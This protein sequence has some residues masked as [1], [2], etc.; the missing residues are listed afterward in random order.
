VFKNIQDYYSLFGARGV[1]LAIKARCRQTC[2]QFGVAVPG[3]KHLVYLRFR[4]SD[5]S[6]F[7]QVVVRRG[8]DIDLSTSPRFIVDAG[9]NVGLT[10]VFY[11]NKY[12]EAKILAIEPEESNFML[13]KKNSAF[14][15]QI[16]PVQRALWNSNEEL[17][18][19]D[20]GL[21]EWAF[22]TRHEPL[23]ACSR[24]RT[25]GLTM[26]QVLAEF[27]G[28]YVDLL[29][30]DIEG[31]EKEVF[32]SSGDWIENVGAIAIELHDGMKAGCSRAFKE[33]VKEFATIDHRGET[34]FVARPEY[35]QKEAPIGN[36]GMLGS[37]CESLKGTRDPVFRIVDCVRS[38]TIRRL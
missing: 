24:G 28:G 3:F 31:A 14:Y 16:I 23:N 36:A 34:T 6:T 25:R 33:A 11:A 4:T 8:Y 18:I 1:G 22:Q 38:P 10:S 32:E 12:P 37:G 19:L 21:G 26:G 5:I 13:L 15:P 9:A 7:R 2:V 17:V 30:V 20:A 35:L 27:S 29:K